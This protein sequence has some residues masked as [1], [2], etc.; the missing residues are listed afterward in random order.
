MSY[1]APYWTSPH[2]NW[3]LPHPAELRRTLLNYA[4]PYSATP[5]PTELRRVQTELYTVP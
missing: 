3:A 2:P 1:A 4:A 5:H